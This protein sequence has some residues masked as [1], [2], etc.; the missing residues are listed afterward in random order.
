MSSRQD[1][2]PY[3]GLSNIGR[4]RTHN[5]DA[6]LVD[7][8]LFAVADGL[9][10]HDAG[11]VASEVAV[12]ALREAAPRR[13]DA[14]AL[15]RAVRTAN[16]AVIQ[17]ERDGLG[18]EGMGTTMTAALV[19]GSFI[20]VAHVGDSRAYLY[21][22]GVLERITQDHSLVGDM[23]RQG[24]LT[25][26]EARFHPNRSVITRAL[27][28]DPNMLADTY[29]VDAEP[30]DLL[31]LCS[32]GLTG[33]LDDAH[34][35]DILGSY[36]D[37]TV[38]ARVLVDTA[39]TAGGHDNVSVVVVEIVDDDRDPR[40]PVNRQ[41]GWMS[42]LVWLFA[43][44]AL[45]AIGVFG[46]TQYARSK[47]YLVAEQGTVSLYRGVPGDFAGLTLSWL[48]EETQIPLSALDPVT[49][50]RLTQGVQVED[51]DDG[52][53]LLD[54]MRSIVGTAAESPETTPTPDPVENP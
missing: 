26:E 1:R 44:M 46:L 41:R 16:R 18:S 3:A 54:E 52:R 11:E 39:N 4:V 48:E 2:K 34:I 21:H 31:L 23:I 32:D 28:S 50:A 42:A 25:E 47:A 20:A 15:G 5:E 43:A 27:G 6:V 53:E 22:G 45:V 12:E 24:T 14:K 38:I 19:E 49:A 36:R 7:A 29:E 17:A 13:A 33:M 35:T 30:G 51:V 37:P 9:G 10:G 8:P 40:V